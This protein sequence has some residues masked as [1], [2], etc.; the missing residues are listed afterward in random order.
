[1]V[2]PA[3]RGRW[4]VRASLWGIGVV[5]LLLLARP[6]T[7]QQ[8]GPSGTKFSGQSTSVN[9]GSPAFMTQTMQRP[10]VFA[11]VTRPN[12]P[13]PINLSSFIATMPN[14]HNTMLLRNIFGSPQTQV[15]PPPPKKKT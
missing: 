6:A 2:D 12:F 7:A 3:K 4:I 1:M 13:S 5:A 10:N 8:F 15:T 9:S 11:P 14:L